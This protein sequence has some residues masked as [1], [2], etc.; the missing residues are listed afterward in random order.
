MASSNPWPYFATIPN[1]TQVISTLLFAS[2]I[3]VLLGRVAPKTAQSASEAAA[4]A[5]AAF[6]GTIARAPLAGF[7]A[8]DLTAPP[9]AR[10]GPEPDE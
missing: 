6:G 9:Q 10:A 1:R 3:V 5:S 7:K 2:L 4:S 8:R